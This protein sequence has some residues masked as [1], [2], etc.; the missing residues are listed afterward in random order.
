[1]KSEKELVELSFDEID[2]VSAGIVPLIALGISLVTLFGGGVALG[3]NVG[4]R[5][6]PRRAERQ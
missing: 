6:V 3:F 4:G 1:M 5:L 2:V